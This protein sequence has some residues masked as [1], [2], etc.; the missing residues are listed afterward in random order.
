MGKEG[1]CTST[2]AVLAD[3]TIRGW[4]GVSISAVAVLCLDTV[5]YT[6]LTRAAVAPAII[7]RNTQDT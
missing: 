4:M 3:V 5:G 1:E 7:C 6:A 2:P